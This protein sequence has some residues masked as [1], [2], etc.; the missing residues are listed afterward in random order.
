[1]QDESYKINYEKTLERL[2]LLTNEN[3]ELRKQIEDY[4]Y[5]IQTFNP[6]F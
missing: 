2:T 3:Q 1:M 6:R 5:Q 4:R